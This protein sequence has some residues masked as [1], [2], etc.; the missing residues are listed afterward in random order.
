MHSHI[1][2][3]NEISAVLRSYPVLL[4]DLAFV[5]WFLNSLQDTLMKTVTSRDG[6]RFKSGNQ[7]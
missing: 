6:L 3:V 5:L 2:V 4:T 7:S 1:L